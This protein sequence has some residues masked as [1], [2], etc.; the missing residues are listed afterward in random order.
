MNHL[1]ALPAHPP[2]L[3]P[4]LCL[5]LGVGLLCSAGGFYRIVYFISV[6]Y[7]FSIA[8]M[9]LT[10][11]L[12]YHASLSPLIGL[13]LAG[14][15][16]Y[17]L[18]LAGY[19]IARERQPSY[20]KELAG[21]EQRGA[22]IKGGVKLAIWVSVA[23]LY[24][25]MFSPVVFNLVA[26]QKDLSVSLASLWIGVPVMAIGLFLESFAD[27]EKSR[28]KKNSPDRFCDVGTYRIVRCPNYLGEVIFWTG[29]LIAGISAY[30]SWVAWACAASGY[31]CIVLIMMGSAKR[32]ERK[33]DERY[34]ADPEYQ[35]YTRRV[36]ILFPLLPIYSFKNLKVYL[37]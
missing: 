30:Q 6:G 26:R 18:R 29:Q 21:I 5:L 2:S 1:A 9:A 33:Q 28:F 12:T 16:F 14:L 37:G 24:V 11:A 7:G 32:L 22:H 27:H 3:W 23:V 15:L 8:A 4:F 13:Q 35:A 34:G 10:T 31:L 25:L 17:G 20:K 19:L 36:P